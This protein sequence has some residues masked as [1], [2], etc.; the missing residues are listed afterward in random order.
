MYL[1]VQFSLNVFRLNRTVD[2]RYDAAG[3]WLWL[4]E[5][6]YC[7]NAS[8]WSDLLIESHLVWAVNVEVSTQSRTHRFQARSFG[9]TGES[10]IVDICTCIEFNRFFMRSEHKCSIDSRYKIGWI[11]LI[12][13]IKIIVARMK[14]LWDLVCREENFFFSLKCNVE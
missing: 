6:M 5:L 3:T 9:R 11:R 2:G 1:K 7:S 12:Y 13:K 8:I 10:F 4:L 14:L